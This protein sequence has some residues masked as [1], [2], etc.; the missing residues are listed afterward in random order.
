MRYI[1]NYSEF[2]QTNEG[3]RTWLSTFLLMANLGLVPL[4]VKSADAQTR[5]E[6]IDNQPQDKIDAAKFVTFLNKYGFRKSLDQVWTEFTNSD[7]TVT[8]S[9]DQVQKYIN[10]DG[11]VYRID[12]KY[13]VQDFSG[14]DM[15]KFKPENWMTDM[16]SFIPD[17]LEPR[18]NNFISDYEQKTSIEIGIITVKNLDGNDI[19]D[20]SQ[21]QFERLGVGKKGADNGILIVFSMEDRKSR[22]HTG[23]GIEEFLTDAQCSRL[24]QNVVK[25][26]FKKGE[27]FDGTMTLLQSIREELGDQAYEEK[28]EFLKKKKEADEKEFQQRMDNF[29][30]FLFTTFMALIVL[31][32]IAYGIYKLM[33]H[34]KDKEEARKAKEELL[35]EIDKYLA[36]SKSIKSSLPKDTGTGSEQLEG[37]LT[38][39]RAEIEGFNIDRK[40][41]D[42][43]EEYLKIINSFNR[44]A[45]SQI[46][47]Y[48]KYKSNILLK[49]SD[50]KNIDSVTNGAYSKINSAIAAYQ[51]VKDFGYSAPTPSS[52]AELEKASKIASEA[53]D[54]LNANKLDQAIRSYDEYVSTTTGIIA[55]GAAAIAMLSSI[56]SAKSRVEKAND[57]VDDAVANMDRYSKWC[58]QSERDEAMSVVDKILPTISGTDFLGLEKKLDSILGAIDSVTRKWKGRKED[59]EEKERRKREEERRRKRQEE[60]EEERRRRS[61]YSSSSYS[62]SSSSDSGSS[63]GGFGGGDSGGGGSSGDW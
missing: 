53:K 19:F 47:Q 38:K 62:S 37:Y 12:Q 39:L 29:T 52:I 7:S 15:N 58:R 30:D 16:G 17:S 44:K 36:V 22:I 25:P 40:V 27:Y 56:K 20:Y 9:F 35:R 43:D 46:E 5:K 42:T 28:V 61:Y 45:F 60:E 51:A 3:L 11:K 8:S 21:D 26:Y 10:Q 14:V 23:R 13:K 32:P 50:V 34:L 6:F 55:T 24:L 41:T 1:S 18:I 31:G 49:V 63:W 4:N 57:I 2:E 54:F 59:E 48:E 33:R